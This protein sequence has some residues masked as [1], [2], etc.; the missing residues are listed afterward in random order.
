MSMPEEASAVLVDRLIRE[1]VAAERQ[2]CIEDTCAFCAAGQ[3]IHMVDGDMWHKPGGYIHACMA[4]GI[5]MRIA[6][7]EA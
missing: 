7:E 2:Q 3:Q 6:R 5:H 1:A 4:R